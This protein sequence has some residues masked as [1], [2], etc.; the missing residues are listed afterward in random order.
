MFSSRSDVLG[1]GWSLN[2]TPLINAVSVLVSQMKHPWDFK[3]GEVTDCCSFSATYLPI[4]FFFFLF[5]LSAPPLFFNSCWSVVFQ[6]RKAV[7]Y[8]NEKR[9]YWVAFSSSDPVFILSHLSQKVA[10]TV[11]CEGR[12]KKSGVVVGGKGEIE[13][14]SE[15]PLMCRWE[16]TKSRVKGN[17]RGLPLKGDLH[18]CS[19]LLVGIWEI[20]V[21]GDALLWDNLICRMGEEKVVQARL[22]QNAVQLV[23][24]IVLFD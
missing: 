23:V 2:K 22:P 6:S 18:C 21:S 7:E 1:P 11:V 3:N 17:P 19:V 10:R 12:I 8:N 15:K 24:E 5:F 9:K 14:H 13:S 20:N 4:F 16:V